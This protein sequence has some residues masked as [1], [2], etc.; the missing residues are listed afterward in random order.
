M[1]YAIIIPDR[2]DRP[3]LLSNCM[4][5]LENQDFE[6]F[7][8]V[9][10]NYPAKSDECDITWRY[11]TAYDKLRWKGFEAIF[12]IEN[13]DYYAPDYL[14]TMLNAWNEAGRP[15]IFG[16]NYTYYYHI[17]IRKYEKLVHLRRA[18]AM[19]TLIKPD[20]AIKWP[21]DNYPYTDLVLWDQL[22]GVTFAPEKVI[23]IGIKH[24]I[25]QTGGH[26][27]STKLE[28]YQNNDSEM[29]FLKSNMDEESFNFYKS[30]HEKIQSNF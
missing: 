23:S 6:D 21:L 5:M 14:K 1:K 8:L 26:Y 27:H 17:G 28:R 3:E 7:H 13:D 16:T 18:S 22:N 10:A 19:N 24:N 9:I 11:R 29:L 15:D 4:R 25:G 20:L 2:G 30:L 12:F